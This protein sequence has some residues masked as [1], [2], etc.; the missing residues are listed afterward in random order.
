MLSKGMAG[1]LCTTRHMGHKDVAALLLAHEAEVNAKDNNG[2]T[3]LH[4]A[5]ARPQGR[6]GIAAP[7]RR[8]RINIER[9]GLRLL[10]E[11]FAHLNPMPF[12]AAAQME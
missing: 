12:E 11:L 8:P 4:L 7:A 6:G 1:R 3:P 2:D 9:Y 10:P 5:A